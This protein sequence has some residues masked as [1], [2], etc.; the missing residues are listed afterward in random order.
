MTATIPGAG[1]LL[2]A[3]QI[4]TIL[5][6]AG[7]AGYHPLAG[8]VQV[9][10]GAAGVYTITFINQLAGTAVPLMTRVNGLTNA[11]GAVNVAPPTEMTTGGI[12]GVN[13]A[14][15]TATWC[16]TSITA[17]PPTTPLACCIICPRQASFS[18]TR[19]SNS[20]WGRRLAGP[21]SSR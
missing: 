19:F 12:R 8:N 11:A 13:A 21:I 3:A 15:A 1:G 16:M 14:L 17:I 20:F 18:G 6:N 10:Q 2:T 4:Q 5:S 7:S 9:T